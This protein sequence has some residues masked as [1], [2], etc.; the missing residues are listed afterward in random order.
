MCA[1]RPPD[2]DIYSD[3]GV[4]QLKHRRDEDNVSPESPPVKHLALDKLKDT[5]SSVSLLILPNKLLYYIVDLLGISDLQTYTQVSLILK[6]ISTPRYLNTLNFAP[7]G[8]LWTTVDRD[9]VE[10]LM[11][12]RRMAGFTRPGQ[13]YCSFFDPQEHHL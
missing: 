8:G 9:N 13:L 2:S 4:Q 6:T 5:R 11:V 1:E 3:S 10:A 12:W 7:C